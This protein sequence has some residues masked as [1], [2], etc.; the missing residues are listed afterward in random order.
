V[1]ALVAASTKDAVQ[2]IAADFAQEDGGEIRI[3][4]DDSSK[5]AQQIAEGAP[6]HLYLSANKE[7][8]DFVQEKELT[9]ESTVLLGNSLVIVVPRSN[10][11]GVHKPQDLTRPV[12]NRLAVAGPTVPA[13]L[14]A[15]QALRNLG[16]WGKL[17]GRAISGENVRATLAFVERGEADAGI[18]YSTDARI[19]KQVE[20]VHEFAPRTHDPIRYLLVLL[21]SGQDHPAARRFYDFIQGPQA[22]A[23]FQKYGFQRPGGR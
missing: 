11:A 4:A 22:A 13:G 18:V 16:L 14:Y 6:A 21:D 19:S 7:W 12:V 23:V 8:A 10:P 2:E 5:L 9:R 3:S 15:R 1:L 17:E 20:Q